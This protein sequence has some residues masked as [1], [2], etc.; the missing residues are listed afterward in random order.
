MKELA[1]IRA[2][3]LDA[4]QQQARNHEISHW[5]HKFNDACY[6]MEDLKDEFEIQ[7]LRRQVLEQGSILACRFRMGNKIKKAN[8]MLNEIAANKAKFLSLK[9][10]KLMSYIVRGKP[11]HS[12]DRRYWEN[13]PGPIGV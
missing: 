10:M 5:L 11:T 12:W 1:A 3:V 8:E 6:E 4:E 2:V 9:N 7:A 13:Y